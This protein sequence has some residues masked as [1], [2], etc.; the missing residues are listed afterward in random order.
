MRYAMLIYGKP[1]NVRADP[2]VEILPPV[3]GV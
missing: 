2:A 3:T 1:G